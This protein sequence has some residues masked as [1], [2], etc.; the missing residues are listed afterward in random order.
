MDAERDSEAPVDGHQQL[1]L[2][3]GGLETVLVFRDGFEL[4]CFASFPLLDD[5]AGRAALRAYFARFV[6]IAE[7]HGRPLVLDTVTWRAN[8]DWGARLGYDRGRLAQANR[9]AVAFARE[10]ADGRRGVTINGVVGPRGD[11]YVVGEPMSA[12]QAADYHGYQIGVLC[13]AGVDQITGLTLTY[14]EEAIGIV[15]AAA[16]QGVPVV[17]GLTVETDGRLPDGTTI[18]AAVERVDAATGSAAEF[19]LIN[20]AHPTHIAAGLDGTPALARVGGLRFN[21]S[22]RSHAELDAAE[23][24]DDGDPEALAR[25]AAK[26]RNALP[27]IRLLG[28]C[29][30]TDHRHVAALAAAWDDR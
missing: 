6:E 29:C 11:G 30:G 5:E 16:A 23:Q 20:C 17:A 15:G 22:R 25:D 2:T 9:D 8:P 10:L 3:D 24:L 18:A 28:G 4:P 27:S 21:A 13:D 7:R 1:A 12:E 26:L 14:P 19:F